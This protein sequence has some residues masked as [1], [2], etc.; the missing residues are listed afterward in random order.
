MT[1]RSRREGRD[2]FFLGCHCI[3]IL[4]FEGDGHIECVE[5]KFEDY[6]EDKIRRLRPDV[7]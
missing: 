4:A 6:E 1:S 5:E 7:V 3:H 2:S